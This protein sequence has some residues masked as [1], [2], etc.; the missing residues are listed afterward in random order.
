M[1]NKKS[2]VHLDWIL[3]FFLF[4]GFVVFAMTF[5]VP[6][7]T[8]EKQGEITYISR[9]KEFLGEKVAIQ[10]VY[11]SDMTNSSFLVT[12]ANSIDIGEY[13]LVEKDMVNDYFYYDDLLFIKK[14]NETKNVILKI[15]NPIYSYEL[16]NEYQIYYSEN[17]TYNNYF[18]IYNNEDNLTIDFDDFD[19]IFDNGHLI[20]NINTGKEKFIGFFDVNYSSYTRKFFMSDDE[21]IKSFYY[22]NEGNEAVF[23]KKQM[24]YVYSK[25]ENVKINGIS[26]SN[27]M[28]YSVE[29]TTS[30]VIE[31]NGITHIFSQ[32]E[33]SG[34]LK[35]DFYFDDEFYYI[36]EFQ[37]LK[38]AI[39][40]ESF[41]KSNT[42]G[43]D[44]DFLNRGFI[45]TKDSVFK[46]SEN[47]ASLD[48]KIV[49]EELGYNFALVIWQGGVM[50]SFNL[51]NQPFYKYNMEKLGN[52]GY[53]FSDRFAMHHVDKYGND[54]ILTIYSILW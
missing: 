34:L 27:N 53:I 45:E 13:D 3:S 35:I 18:Q 43:S 11:L 4:F 46:T 6:K 20:Q 39:I 37:T 23:E 26:V 42:K 33:K 21:T 19:L 12:Y 14:K 41:S 15:N 32:K 44:Y 8:G 31:I 24:K 1:F 36:I 17:L 29:G 54:E 49:S 30:Y 48:Y 25:S 10:E 22:I 7:I 9:I 52:N 38:G 50:D 2:N 16:N 40:A 47:F 5:F 28:T 51:S